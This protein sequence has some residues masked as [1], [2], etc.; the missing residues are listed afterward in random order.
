MGVI[1]N[2]MGNNQE[3]TTRFRRFENK[4]RSL[5]KHRET[6]RTVKG[7]IGAYDYYKDGDE[8]RISDFVFSAVHDIIEC[9]NNFTEKWFSPRFSRFADM[10]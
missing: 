1:Y 4:F 3:L 9:N 5:P 6:I 7:I 8:T 10:K 2:C